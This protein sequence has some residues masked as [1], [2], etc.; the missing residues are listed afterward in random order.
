MRPE[1]EKTYDHAHVEG[2]LYKTWEERGYFHARPNT[3]NRI[4]SYNVCYTKLLRH[5]AGGAAFRA[6]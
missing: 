5:G 4:T 1:M 6:A 3:G 2:K